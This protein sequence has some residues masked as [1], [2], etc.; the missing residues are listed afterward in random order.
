M[1]ARNTTT[2]RRLPAT[3]RGDHEPTQTTRQFVKLPV[4]VLRIRGLTL[5]AKVV[6]AVLLDRVGDNGECWPGQRRV[7]RDCGI[8]L[9]TANRAIA[10]LKRAGLIE[11][12]SPGGLTGKRPG[13]TCRYRVQRRRNANVPESPTYANRPTQR[14]RNANVNVGES[15]T[16]SD[17]VQTKG[18]RLN[19]S[20]D[21]DSWK[22]ACSAMTT[23]TLRTDGFRAAWERWCRYRREA[24][25]ALTTSTATAQVKKLEGFGHDQAIRAIDASIA[26]GWAGLFA[27]DGNRPRGGGGGRGNGKADDPDA[28]YRD[29]R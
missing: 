28:K 10:E 23:D 19:K 22:S 24:R 12:T 25:R 29:L 1:P 17:K 27:P 3:E 9:T 14:M 4:D 16:E 2:R 6:Y 21:V 7:A 13:R 20:R 15:H 8:D 11:V 26:N 18:A 5:A